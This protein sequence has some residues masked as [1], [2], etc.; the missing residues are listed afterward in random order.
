MEKCGTSN[1]CN[2]KAYEGFSDECG[3][4][5]LIGWG[6]KGKDFTG[7]RKSVK[8]KG[9]QKLTGKKCPLKYVYTKNAVKKHR[10]KKGFIN[11][12]FNKIEHKLCIKNQNSSF[13]GGY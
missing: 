9:I 6:Y 7:G 2:K 5:L 13:D 10:I 8:Q 4:F 1:N 11:I 3:T 12:A